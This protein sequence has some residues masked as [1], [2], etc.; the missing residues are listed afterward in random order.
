MGENR[1]VLGTPFL[2]DIN[3]FLLD[4]RTWVKVK[5]TPFSG[6]LDRIG[7]YSMCTISDNETFEKTFIFGGLSY[8]SI[9]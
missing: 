6:L 7:N 9:G 5:Y 2:N 3:L 8:S 4:Q 1:W